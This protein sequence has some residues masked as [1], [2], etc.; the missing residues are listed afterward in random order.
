[1]RIVACPITCI[2]TFQGVRAGF[3]SASYQT[4]TSH[5]CTKGVK[6]QERQASYKLTCTSKTTRHNKPVNEGVYT[7]ELTTSTL[8][9]SALPMQHP[10]RVER[11]LQL[12]KIKITKYRTEI[13]IRPHEVRSTEQNS[14]CFEKHNHKPCSTQENVI[15]SATR[16]SSPA[17]TFSV[18]RTEYPF[19]I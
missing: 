2:V 17:S 1:M 14:R 10:H 18:Q 19:L 3:S 13:Q 9:Y 12:S 4:T 8:T 6:R 7:T 15:T 5:I 11:H 16:A